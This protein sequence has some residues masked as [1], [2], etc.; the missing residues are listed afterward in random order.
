M[1]KIDTQGYEDKVLAGATELI[2]RVDIVVIEN[3][4]FRFYDNQ[5]L[6][7]DIFRIL[8]EKGF[9]YRGNIAQKKDASGMPLFEDSIFIKA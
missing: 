1:L 7:E 6:F 3:S 9:K 8:S 2:K 4:F 5:P